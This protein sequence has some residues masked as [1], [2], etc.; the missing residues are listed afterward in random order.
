MRRVVSG[1]RFGSREL[2][3]LQLVGKPVPLR[4]TFGT[5]EANQLAIPFDA[6]TVTR[7]LPAHDRTYLIDRLRRRGSV[8]RLLG[9]VI[10]AG[11]FGL[12][13]ADK[14]DPH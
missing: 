1:V 9:I 2:F 11:G 3:G 12:I 13:T 14:N 5:T 4:L 6:A 8:G 7:D 10:R